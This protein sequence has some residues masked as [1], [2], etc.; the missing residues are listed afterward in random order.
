MIN[1][2]LKA[3]HY[4][5]ITESLMGIVAGQ[6][7]ALLNRIKN[8]TQGKQDDDLIIVSADVSDVVNIF[9]LTTMRPEGQVNIINTEMSD[10]L[11]VQIQ[12]NAGQAEWDSLAAQLSQIRTTN[13]SYTGAAIQRGKTFLHG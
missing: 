5:F 2:Q 3:K 12:A 9:Y 7:F 10:L 11:F 8:A 13:L 6:Y 1:V 4:Y